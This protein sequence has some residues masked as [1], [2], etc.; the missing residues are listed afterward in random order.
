MSIRVSRSANVI[1]FNVMYPFTPGM[2]FDHDYYRDKH[3]PLLAQRLGQACRYYTVDKGV[4][5]GAPGAPLPFAAACSVY[6]DSLEALQAAMNPHAQEILGDIS[7]YTDAKPV[8]W[9]SDVVVEHS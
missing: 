6:A 9:I 3:M 4:A 1:K 7:N 8:I 2:R 5:G